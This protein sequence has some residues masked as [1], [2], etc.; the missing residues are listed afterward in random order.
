MAR[1]RQTRKQKPPLTVG[2]CPLIRN[3]RPLVSRKESQTVFGQKTLTNGWADTDCNAPTHPTGVSINHTS[4][5]QHCLTGQDEQAERAG[6]SSDQSVSQENP[7]S[8]NMQHEQPEHGQ[9]PI[10]LPS[11]DYDTDQVTQRLPVST[12]RGRFVLQLNSH[13]ELTLCRAQSE[14]LFSLPVF[15]GKLQTLIRLYMGMHILRVVTWV[16]G[17]IAGTRGQM[18][19]NTAKTHHMR[20]LRLVFNLP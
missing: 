4:F 15:L 9:H 13:H 10:S 18:K 12:G 1:K 16:A 3:Q 17:E 2:M 6:T 14:T 19:L 7:H 11:D 20:M 8:K 5:R